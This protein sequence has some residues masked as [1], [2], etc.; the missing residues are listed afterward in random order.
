MK[1][2]LLISIVICACCLASC[3]GDNAQGGSEFGNP[4]ARDVRGTVENGSTT[5]ASTL[6]S[7]LIPTALAAGDCPAGQVI[8]TDTGAQT[9]TADLDSNCAFSLSL[10]INKAYTISF[11]QGDQ[12]VATMIFNHGF[13]TIAKRYL[14]VSAGSGAIDLGLIQIGGGKATPANQPAG[15]SD[16]DGDG[17]PDF[18]D[19]DDDNDGILDDDELDCDL[20]GILGDY[21]EDE[22]DCEEND[23]DEAIVLEVYPYPDQG[24]D[25]EDDLVGLD[26]DVEA[27]FSCEIDLTAFLPEMFY[28]ASDTHEV[29]CEYFSFDSD[30]GLLCDHQE[31]EFL[32]DT[33]YTA[34]IQDLPCTDGQTVGAV[35]WSWQTESDDD[36]T[37]DEDETDEG[38]EE[39]GD[40][41]EEE[42]DEDLEDEE[43]F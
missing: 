31:D 5:A 29:E 24:I 4:S 13:S 12:F 8:A 6:L 38:E 17:I 40:E 33:I 37:E 39:L 11:T 34:T 19:E 7:L 20:N 27:R 15:Q 26:E 14:V 35:F 16:L 32:P 42:L 21:D 23:S 36:F 18:D 9:V 43:D 22:D 30:E 10:V 25:D 28:I 2:A 1:R 41:E 3:G